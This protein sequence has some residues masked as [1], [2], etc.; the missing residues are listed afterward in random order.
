M[1]CPRRHLTNTVFLALLAGFAAGPALAQVKP[2]EELKEEIAEKIRNNGVP[3]FDLFILP[4]DQETPWKI[5]G[6]CNG[7]QRLPSIRARRGVTDRPAT[8]RCI[9]NM[10]ACRIFN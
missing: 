8:A 10:V 4:R 2:C 1:T 5:V 7:G 6:T 3:A 9:A